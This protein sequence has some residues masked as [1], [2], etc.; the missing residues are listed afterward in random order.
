MNHSKII[1]I[2]PDQLDDMNSVLRSK[3]EE[4]VTIDQT[5]KV[6]IKELKEELAKSGLAVGLAAPQIG[7]PKR[8]FVMNLSKEKTEETDVI[9]NPTI[10]A[11]SDEEKIGY[12]S[13]M[14]IPGWKG[15][16]SRWNNVDVDYMD[17]NGK[18]QTLTAEGFRARVIQH[19]IDH[20]DG[21]LFTDRF[22]SG[23]ELERTD[24]FDKKN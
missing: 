12:E 2:G 11:H 9:I 6:E 7:I 3:C 10:I 21:I 4:I 15:Q 20:L 22:S 1:E 19:E 13:C 5:V 18:Q 8:I 17:E 16:V 14:S 24:L 23:V